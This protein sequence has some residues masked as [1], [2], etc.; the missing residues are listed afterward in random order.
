MKLILQCFQ[1]FIQL[2]GRMDMRLPRDAFLTA[3]CKSCLPPKFAMS[4]ITMQHHRGARSGLQDVGSPDRKEGDPVVSGLIRGGVV[5][6]GGG[7][8]KKKLVFSGESVSGGAVPGG[9]GGGGGGKTT[10][11][12]GGQKGF[13]STLVC[14]NL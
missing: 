11:L 1:Q 12:V 2:C 3:L 13:Q 7:G 10:T 6:G 4:L 8:V 5:E 14:E 9:E